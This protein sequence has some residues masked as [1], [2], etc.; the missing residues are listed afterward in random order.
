M[1]TF[2]EFLRNYSVDELAGRLDARF[3]DRLKQEYKKYSGVDGVTVG[4]FR[5][6][7]RKMIG[8]V[9]KRM[10]TPGRGSS[11][12]YVFTPFRRFEIPKEGGKPGEKRPISVA[13]ISGIIAQMPMAD[14]LKLKLDSTF[15]DSSFGYRS[16][17]SAKQAVKRVRS[18]IRSGNHWVFDADIKSFFDSVDH[19]ILLERITDRFPNDRLLHD[20]I[21]RFL[22]TGHVAIADSKSRPRNI[23]SPKGGYTPRLVGLPQGGMLSGILANMMLDSVDRLM[24]EHYRDLVYVRYADDFVVL[25]NKQG[26]LKSAIIAIQRELAN[27]KLQL[28][29]DKTRTLN[30]N[31][32]RESGAEQ[33]FD[34]LGYRFRKDRLLIKRS[35]MCKMKARLATIIHKWCAEPSTV[36]KLIWLLNRRIQGFLYDDDGD[37]VGRNWAR[38]FSLISHAGQFRALDRWLMSELLKYPKIRH[39]GLNKDLFRRLGL[40]SF[41][42]LH[43]S[44]KRE[45]SRPQRQRAS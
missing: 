38:Y 40:Q 16:G 43:Y 5:R 33:C 41:V 17:R 37:F 42:K 13:S 2:E 3:F 4:Q 15:S 34:F 36:S 44:M 31:R 6:G 18:A 45:L 28:H 1:E 11:T 35:N 23:R 12:R 10:L 24:N 32:P 14:Y 7:P 29:P 39:L 25:S 20:L 21:R 9:F 8:S 30:L 26:R 27:L 19:N 22:R